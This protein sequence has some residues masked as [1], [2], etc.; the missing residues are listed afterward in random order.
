MLRAG[1]A[2][3]EENQKAGDEARAQ[4]LMRNLPRP[5]TQETEKTRFCFSSSEIAEK[6]LLARWRR[7]FICLTRFPKVQRSQ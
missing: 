4:I 7:K 1:A 6:L 5:S 3:R 2:G